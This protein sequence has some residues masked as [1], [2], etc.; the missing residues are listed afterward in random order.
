M[1][2]LRIGALGTA[3]MCA[4][5]LAAMPAMAHDDQAA[6]TGASLAGDF[7]EGDIVVTARKREESLQDVPISISVLS[8]EALADQSAVRI[9]DAFASLPNVQFTSSS[10]GG[11]GITVR[12]LSSSTNN[13]GIESAV[14][15]Y[16]DEVYLPRPTA[17][18]Q[19]ALDIA[20]IEVL[21]G[22][23]GTLFGRNTIAGVINIVTADPDDRLTAAADATYGRFDLMQ[24]RAA[25][26][27]PIGEHAGFRLSAARIKRD[28]WFEDRT[29]GHRDLAGEDIW[30]LR[31]KL[32]VEPSAGFDI[33]ATLD[34]SK[35]K[36]ATGNNEVLQGPFAAFEDGVN[37][38]IASNEINAESRELVTGSVRANLDLGGHVLTSVTGYQDA[39]Y[40]RFND[41]D[42]TALDVLSTGAPEEFEFFSQELRLSSDNAG[43]LGY[44]FGAYYSSLNLDGNTNAQ[45][46]SD[47]LLAIGQA[48]I[49]GYQE[50]IVTTSHIAGKSYALFASATWQATD[51]IIL[52]GGLRY[53]WERKHLD[54]E[55]VVTPFF[56]APGV[57]LGLIYLFGA[58]VPAQRQYY[59][60][61]ALSGDA[62]I[63]YKWTPDLTSYLR[64]SRGYKAGGFDTTV[65]ASP[66]PGSL[67]FESEFADLYEIGIKGSLARG[68][69]QFSLAGFIMDFRDKQEQVFNGVNFLTSNAATASSKG[70]EAEIVARPL[71][72]L[73]LSGALGYADATYGTFEDPLAGIDN[74]GNRLPEAPRWS[75]SASAEFTPQLTTDW[76]L[77]SRAE[78]TFRSSSFVTNDNDPDFRTRS[79]ALINARIGVERSDGSLGLFAWGRNITGERYLTGGFD[80]LGSTYIRRNIPSTWGIELRARF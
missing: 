41:Q 28:G 72:D 37:D 12:G 59:R 62:T 70:V 21:R 69:V 15:V 54:Y 43:P 29:P 38:S 18:S 5:A 7:Q 19:A 26:S 67:R 33:T 44:I 6:D 4:A 46:G 73:R 16:V 1:G 55:Q 8:A 10:I 13:F 50:S 74:S 47:A 64:Y 68:A 52:N 71:R 61:G 27:A 32:R 34:Y 25:A 51:R 48:P 53:S 36:G 14:G 42:Y 76:A 40:R 39:R 78:V 58:D 31:G 56:L 77:Y 65:S 60:D 49:S 57:P 9:E 11:V 45:L 23:Q 66:D 63:S 20:R 2:R 35:D 80:F 30:A 22:P 17:F 75:G 24:L 3:G 79:H